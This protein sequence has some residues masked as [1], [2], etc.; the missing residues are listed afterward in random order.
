[1]TD[2]SGNRDDGA[3]TGVVERLAGDDVE[4]SGV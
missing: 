4:R 1:M 2:H 3:A